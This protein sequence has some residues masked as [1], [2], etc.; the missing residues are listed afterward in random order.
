[1]GDAMTDISAQRRHALAARRALS[2]ATHR[3]ASEL[4]CSRLARLSVFR[5]ARHIGFYWPLASET[6]PRPLLAALRRVQRAYLPR[7]NDQRLDFMAIADDDFRA[8]LSSL[9]VYEPCGTRARRVEALDLLILPLAAFDDH[10]HRIGLGGGYYDRTL[11]AY[12]TG[13]GFRRPRLVG[14]AFEA[15]R[16][17]RIDSRPWDIALDAVVSNARVYPRRKAGPIECD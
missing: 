16:V 17:D 4:A 3:Q 6:D 7:V 12:A 14:L 9:G 15:Q 10:A 1:M 5:R 8:R 11:A 13:T 2:I